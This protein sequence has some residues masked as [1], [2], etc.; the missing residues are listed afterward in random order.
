LRLLREG[1]LEIS[2]RIVWARKKPVTTLYG[3]EFDS[4][5]KIRPG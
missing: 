5:R 1:G 3:L 4:V 2:A